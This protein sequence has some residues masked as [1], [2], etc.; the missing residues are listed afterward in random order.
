MMVDN[1]KPSNT[2]AT[3]LDEEFMDW[4]ERDET[5]ISLFKHC[6]AGKHT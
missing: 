1:F 6:V 3:P 2:T 4:E 5:K